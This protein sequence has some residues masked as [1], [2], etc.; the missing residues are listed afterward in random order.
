MS[1][2]TISFK[3]LQQEP[4]ISEMFF[5]LEK[6]FNK[7]GIDFYLLE[8]TEQNLLAAAV[9][10]FASYSTKQ[11]VDF[12]FFLNDKNTYADLKDYLITVE[13][14]TACKDNF[15]ILK[16]KDVIQIDLVPF[17]EF[18][19]KPTKAIIALTSLDTFVFNDFCTSEDTTATKL[20]DKKRF[21]SCT[22][23][24]IVLL[25]LIAFQEHPEIRRDIIKD[26]NKIIKH[27]FDMYAH[28]IYKKHNDLFGNYDINLQ[29]IAGRI[30]GRDM[31]KTIDS[32]E[33]LFLR[34]KKILQKNTSNPTSSD[35]A[36]IMADFSENTIE[37]NLKILKQ[38]KIGYLEN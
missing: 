14:F 21:K 8:T 29:W 10:E 35:I 1:N 26:I 38:I 34:V 15:F 32:N 22:L 18:K 37:D 24:G 30:I 2:D 3:L 17:G 13:E 25:K 5:A 19:I 33:N 7:Y 23:P 9:N 36:K 31:R 12:S 28:E 11:R 16:W 6:G 4:Y 27:F 20:V